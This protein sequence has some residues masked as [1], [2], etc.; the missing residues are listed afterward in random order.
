[1]GFSY[2]I[3]GGGLT[4]TA[5][6]CQFV[7][8]LKQAIVHHTV[9]A[10]TIAIQIFEKQDTFGPGFPHSDKNVMPFHITNMC[11]EDMGIR[12]GDPTDFQNWMRTQRKRLTRLFP[13]L[14][15]A[16]RNQTDCNH[17]PRA[18]MGE[19]LKEKFIKACQNARDLG[20]EVVLHSLCEVTDLEETN[21]K[22]RL[23]VK[24]LKSGSIF[25]CLADRVL[26]ATG[27]WFETEPKDNYFFS[28][29]P[30]KILL[31]RI[32]EGENVAVIG[33]S[34]SAIEVV[35]TLTSDGLFI[36]ND[37]GE[38]V[39]VPPDR[40]RRFA[41]YS[42]KGLMPKVRGKMGGYQNK[43]LTKKNVENL[44]AQNQGHL[45]LTSVFQLLDSEL[46]AAYGHKVNWQEI[47]NPTGAPVDRMYGYIEDAK[48]GDGP[49]GDQ[50]WQTI[51]CQSLDF[52]RKIYLSLSLKERE[53][54]DKEYTSIFF[55]HAASQP[56]INAEKMAALMKADIVNVY[57]LGNSYKLGKNDSGGG[58]EFIYRDYKGHLKRNAYRYVIDARGQDRS[59]LTDSSVLTKNLIGKGIVQI[60]ETQAI[61]PREAEGKRSAYQLKIKPYSYKTGSIWI[62][63]ETHLV[64]KPTSG[65]MTVWSKALYAVGA[66]TRGQII[67]ASMA[68]GI[69]HSTDRIA[70]DLVDYLQQVNR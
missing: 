24:R 64:M 7:D 22:I 13:D 42:R 57:R 23:T 70:T 37:A 27:H 51:L 14:K 21:D 11:A 15:D 18:F 19:Y 36:R 67:D 68:Y 46:E 12:L 31:K 45:S 26:L 6:L 49:D 34:L 17:Y 66:M 8:K 32:P 39:Y 33:T 25:S 1:M 29:W 10:S 38:R 58:Y 61:Q 28:P 43:F 41:L 65:N 69:V 3:I 20:L 47:T 63:P 62:D 30:A 4:G 5:M 53:Y 2:A 55:T 40:P 44:I 59:I 35:L 48:K 54:F 16:L 52:V 56:I 9:D 60:E 50:M